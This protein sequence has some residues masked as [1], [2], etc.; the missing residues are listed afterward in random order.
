M[1]GDPYKQNLLYFICDCLSGVRS[2]PGLALVCFT[3]G[4]LSTLKEFTFYPEKGGSTLGTP[5]RGK[6]S[7]IFF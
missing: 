5:E 2:N 7:V 4:Y 1:K 6:A 3:A